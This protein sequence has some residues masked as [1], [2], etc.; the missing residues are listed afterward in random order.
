[1]RVVLVKI[2]L[3]QAEWKMW[4]WSNLCFPA[5]QEGLL[6]THRELCEGVDRPKHHNLPRAHM[7][8]RPYKGNR[9]AEGRQLETCRVRPKLGMPSGSE[10]LEVITGRAKSTVTVWMSE[11]TS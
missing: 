4:K 11:S 3:L 10:S 2:K 1:M 9:R 6:G 5:N 8:H 7:Q